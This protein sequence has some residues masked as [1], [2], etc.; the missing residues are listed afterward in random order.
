MSDYVLVP[1]EPTETMLDEGCARRIDL[2]PAFAGE[3]PEPTAGQVAAT[4]YRAMLSAVPPPETVGL[5]TVPLAVY[6]DNMQNAW[7]ALA[8]V[9]EA[10][11]EFGPAASLEGPDAVLLRGPEP[12][13]E[14]EAIVAALARLL[15]QADAARRTEREAIVAAARERAD[16]IAPEAWRSAAMAVQVR[17]LRSFADAIECSDHL[18][19]TRS[20]EGT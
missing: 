3:K 18:P 2:Y 16:L 6:R 13:H 15:A 20:T 12:V 11:E 8:M 14:A 1:K 5:E 9:R 10:V 7:A 17:T 4:I 19:A